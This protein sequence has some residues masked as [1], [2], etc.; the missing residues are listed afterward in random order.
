MPFSLQNAAQTFQRFMDKCCMASIAVS[1]MWMIS[2]WSREEHLQHVR[3]VLEHLE[4]H[5]LTINLSK[6]LL[7][8]SSLEF[9][10]PLVS[11]KGIQPLEEKVQ[12]IHVFPQPTSLRKLRV[13]RPGQFLPPI[14]ACVCCN[15]GAPFTCS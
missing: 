11:S 12:V 4:S 15:H 8:M 6:S 13:Y 9:L 3:L 10:G 1:T 5:G 7:G 14:P 2:W